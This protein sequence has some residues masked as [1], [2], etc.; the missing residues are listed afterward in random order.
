P[1]FE[2]AIRTLCN[3]AVGTSAHCVAEAGRVAWIVNA[4][5]TA[6]HAGDYSV[7]KRSI[8]IECNPRMSSADLETI[9]QLIA[10]I[11][12]DYG[13]RIPLAKH[14]DFYN[15]AC[16]GTYAGKLAWL[17]ARAE[18]IRR[19]APASVSP[20]ADPAPTPG[21]LAEDGILGTGSLK[22]IQA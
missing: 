18:D 12:R 13:W 21:K 17:D 8:G 19:G 20:K 5:D 6:W 15:T 3:P 1:G 4:A 10:N 14:N 2:G 11:R 16:P 9:A 7:N 22:K